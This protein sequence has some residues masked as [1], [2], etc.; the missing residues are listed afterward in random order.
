MHPPDVTGA[1][2]V[3][4]DGGGADS[5]DRGDYSDLDGSTHGSA[6]GASQQILFPTV[7]DMSPTSRGSDD[8]P[9]G[10]NRGAWFGG[11]GA[12]QR[13]AAARGQRAAETREGGMR[14]GWGRLWGQ[15]RDADLEMRDVE[16]GVLRRVVPVSILWRRRQPR[17]SRES[18][19]C[20]ARSTG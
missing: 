7:D 11:A 18:C 4:A 10:T 16:E 12:K 9:H 14:T 15:A 3:G 2:L 13:G 20:I 5:H 1:Q 8:S 17:G 6:G 19:L